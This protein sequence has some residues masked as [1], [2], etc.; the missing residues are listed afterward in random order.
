M[1]ARV[2]VYARLVCDECVALWLGKAVRRPDGTV[3][4]FKAGP[5]AAPRTRLSR[6]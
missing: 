3:R 4:Y 5:A 1:G 2:S 6:S